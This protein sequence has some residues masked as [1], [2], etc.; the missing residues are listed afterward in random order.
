[1]NYLIKVVFVKAIYLYHGFFAGRVSSAYLPN[2]GKPLGSTDG[3]LLR[4]LAFHQ[5]QP[6]FDICGLSLLLVLFSVPRGFSPGTPVFPSPL[7]LGVICGLSLLL[8]LFCSERFFSGY[9]GFPLSLSV[10]WVCCWFSERF[11]SGYSGFPLSSITNTSK[12]QF[13]P[14][15]SNV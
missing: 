4:V 6:K 12:F 1:M 10:G 13:D 3:A 14:E 5:R 11:F 7:P 2:R 9:S 8:V 15:C